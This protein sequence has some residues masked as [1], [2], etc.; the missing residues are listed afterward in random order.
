MAEFTFLQN[1]TAP[2]HCTLHSL[3]SLSSSN[4]RSNLITPIPSYRASVCGLHWPLVHIYELSGAF[5]PS[6]TSCPY[7]IIS[8]FIANILSMIV[9]RTLRPQVWKEEG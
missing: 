8:N 7:R 9:L 2:D 1:D 3:D 4:V 5:P 6:S